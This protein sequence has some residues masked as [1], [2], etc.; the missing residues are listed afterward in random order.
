MDRL[1]FD[2][3]DHKKMYWD[4]FKNKFIR[5]Y[6]YIQRGLDIF[7]QFR[8]V[9][10]AIAGLYWTLKLNNPIILVIMFIVAIP[11]LAWAGWASVHHIAKVMDFLNVEFSTHW[12]KFTI[13]LNI[14]TLACLEN[15]LKTLKGGKDV[16]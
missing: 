14:K 11:L 8:Y 9:L 13:D 5:Y 15:I 6:F 12:A 1:M 16:K 3:P 10:M 7:N 4:G 2:N